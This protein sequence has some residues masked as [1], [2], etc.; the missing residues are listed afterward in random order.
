LLSERRGS[1]ASAVEE[2]HVDP[3]DLFE[4]GRYVFVGDEPRAPGLV[5]RNDPGE[6]SLLFGRHV[7]LAERS[8]GERVED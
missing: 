8:A 6:L 7:F 5:L 4:R 3:G 2:E 1:R